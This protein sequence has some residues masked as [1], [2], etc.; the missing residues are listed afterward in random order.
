VVTLPAT[1]S[2]ATGAPA[3]PTIVGPLIA[4]PFQSRSTGPFADVRS[5]T[6]VSMCT[7]LPD[8]NFPV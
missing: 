2:E 5:E 1:N 6:L 8:L 4:A 3:A 7:F